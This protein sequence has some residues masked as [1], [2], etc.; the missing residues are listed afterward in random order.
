M[1]ENN[2]LSR[3][4]TLWMQGV[5]ALLIMLMHFVMPVSYKHPRAHETGRNIVCRLLLEKKKLSKNAVSEYIT[6]TS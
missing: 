5:S 3:Q 2:I 4:N 6:T 1:T